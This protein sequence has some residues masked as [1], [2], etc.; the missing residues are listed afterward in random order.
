MKVH[1]PKLYNMAH[2][3]ALNVL[4][5]SKDLTIIFIQETHR[6]SRILVLPPF[7]YNDLKTLMSLTSKRHQ[8]FY[9]VIL[10]CSNCTPFNVHIFAICKDNIFKFSEN[11]RSFI[12]VCNF[13]IS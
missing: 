5:L 1:Y 6:L 9:D 3:L 12:H 11:T 2:L 7:N 13:K 10:D 8:Q 4:L